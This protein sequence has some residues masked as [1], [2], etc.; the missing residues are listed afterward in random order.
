[1][2]F[3]HVNNAGC[4]MHQRDREEALALKPWEVLQCSRAALESLY[5]GLIESGEFSEPQEVLWEPAKGPP[6]WLE[7]RRHAQL[8]GGRW[9]VVVLTRDVTARKEADSRIAYL[10]RTY[11]VLSGINTLVVRVRDRE[12]LFQEACRIAVEQGKLAMAWIAVV[13]TA[14][15]KLVPVASAGMSD[16]FRAR[17][18]ARLDAQTLTD[19]RDSMSDRVVVDGK[20]FVSN[21]SQNDPRVSSSQ[22]HA[23]QGAHSMAIFPLKASGEAFGVLT[24]YAREIG[25]FHEEELALLNELAG[26]VAYAVEHIEKQERLDYLA[27]YDELTGLAN[28]NLFIERVGQYVR[29]SAEEGRKLAVC[30]LDIERFRNINDSLGRAA[31]D[32]LLRQVA[33]WLTADTGDVYIVARIDSDRFAIVMPIVSGEEAIAR[34]LDQSLKAFLGH[35][36][37][38]NDASYRVAAKVGVALYPDDG[39]DADT[40][41]THAEAALKKAKAGGDRYLFY[42]QRMT[43]TI[44]G[45]L[46]LENQ[47]RRALEMDEYVLHYQ[48]KINAD[49]GKLVG[50]EA[51]IRWN[52]PLTGLVPPGRF[53]PVL[54]ET[55]L[56]HEVGRWALNRR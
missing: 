43:E 55:G 42:A 14:Q 27:Y 11:A 17:I 37:S 1:M 2:R 20:P 35:S 49:S 56:I 18:S 23:A 4:R 45:R 13:D 34:R 46:T 12:V 31:G 10:T 3:V 47:L 6:I 32:S 28:R 8:I 44:A 40:V 36:F 39:E 26:D 7:I 50:A 51:L 19:S 25:F 33:Q 22:F 16:A 9:T 29:S 52:D 5:D 15:D 53:I 41:F 24:L 54:E 38:L 30:L 21:D 48:P